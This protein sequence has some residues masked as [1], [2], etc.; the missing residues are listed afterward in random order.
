MK[1]M[2]I[3]GIHHLMEHSVRLYPVYMIQGHYQF[4]HRRSK[5]GYHRYE[6]I[7]EVEEDV[8]DVHDSHDPQRGRGRGQTLSTPVLHYGRHYL[9]VQ[10]A[11]HCLTLKAQVVNGSVTRCVC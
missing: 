5:H 6:V 10:A 2:L 7:L 4:H 9:Q 8:T 1:D 11:A 3:T